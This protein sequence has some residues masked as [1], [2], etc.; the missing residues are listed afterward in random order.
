MTR[1]SVSMGDDCMA[2]HEKKI[3]FE[4]SDTLYELL[5]KAAEY[6]PPMCDYEWEV[7]CDAEV[8]GRLI[9]GSEKEY[10]IKLERPNIKL[11]SLTRRE[12][13]CR[14]CDKKE[15]LSYFEKVEVLYNGNYFSL[16]LFHEYG[17]IKT[18]LEKGATMITTCNKTF[19]EKY[20]FS[21]RELQWYDKILN[22]HEFEGLRIVRIPNDMNVD[23]EYI[24]I[25]KD[26]V[27]EELNKRA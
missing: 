18:I 24:E 2:P 10:Q 12:I 25:P 13:F 8:I 20:G 21:H 19:A 26:K 22:V 27:I 16:T 4:V 9:S 1:D 3:M 7:M 15:E 14:K 17:D 6:V 23:T 5:H 11:S